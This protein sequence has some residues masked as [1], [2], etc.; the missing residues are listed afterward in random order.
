M[1][2]F[3]NPKSIVIVGASSKRESIGGI[4][5]RNLLDFG[6]PGRIYPVN[7]KYKKIGQLDCYQSISDIKDE[8]DLAVLAIP[9]KVVPDVVEQAAVLKKPIKNFVIIS[10]GFKE[11]NAVGGQLE[12]EIIR[13][14]HK[15]DLKVVG[16]NCLGVLN[17]KYKLNASFSKNNFSAGHIGL[18][19]Q[20]GALTT[21]L[22]DLAESE[23]LGFSKVV[24][25]GNKAVLDETDFLKYLEK[26]KDTK[27]IG[28]YLED[29][30]RGREFIEALHK[31]S[32]S[33]SVVVIK[34][35]N[36]QKA[37]KAVESHTGA[38]AGEAEVAREAIEAS[39]GVYVED[40]LD[41]IENLKMLSSFKKPG[42]DKVVI[43]TNAGGAGV[44][45]TDLIEKNNS[46]SLKDFNLC[47]KR[48]L[49][50][51]IP[52]AGSIN[53]PLDIL[54]D[55][56]T[57]RYTRVLRCL[58]D[59]SNIG[60][61]ICMATAQAQTDIIGISKAI[62]QAN[63]YCSFPVIPVIIGAHANKQAQNVLKP[64]GLNNF[65]FPVQ[66]VAALSALY[67]LDRRKSRLAS[68]HF[69]FSNTPE[70]I[71][72]MADNAYQEFRGAFYFRESMK[73]AEYYQIKVSKTYYF[74]DHSF[75][76]KFPLAIKVDIPRLVH[77]DSHGG[78]ILDIINDSQL[79]KAQKELKEKF[80]EEEIIVQEQT[81]RGI[82][83][84]LGI[85]R[86]INFG[87]VIMLGL[88]GTMTEIYREKILWL[89]PCAKKQV[90]EKL[91]GSILAKIL[92][93]KKIDVGVVIKQVLKV[94]KIA[95]ENEWMRELD[96]NPMIFYSDRDPVTVDIKVF[97]AQ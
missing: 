26:D 13:L 95:E 97:L 74:G 87:P 63:K 42:S 77:K 49:L 96:M 22:F 89:L 48:K 79:E 24:S 30:K 50:K 82:E 4:I 33:K 38:M 7:L 90:E 52:E 37:K 78:V 65:I 12:D 66:A 93:E 25:I 10:A 2:K 58:R 81:F 6:Y 14:A 83:L 15:Y 85:K 34:A 31:A 41:F 32:H 76:P 5:L 47:E 64:Y 75:R 40:F 60:A 72:K 54:G 20:S 3:F 68:A 59:M 71:K 62:A 88:G 18:I 1:D 17:S 36:S 55:A 16:P 57:D 91:N 21:A 69:K 23:N 86:D 19:M 29:I 43:L 45:T 39:G 73:M 53:N 35:G 92:Q 67:E 28:M 56:I 51:V 11:A 94:V 9:A 80:P 61:V 27:I 8:I 70:V 84:I 44:L 46:L